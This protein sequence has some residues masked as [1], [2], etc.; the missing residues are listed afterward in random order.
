M[1]L[2]S[3]TRLSLSNGIFFFKLVVE[4]IVT[5][6]NNKFFFL[7]IE[8]KRVLFQIIFNWQVSIIS[9]KI[10]N[11]GKKKKAQFNTIWFKGPIIPNHTQPTFW[12]HN[13]N[14]IEIIACIRFKQNRA[15]TLFPFE[16][17]HNII[18][19]TYAYL[20]NLTIVGL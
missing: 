2:V 7:K 19:I 11:F 18:K 1:T 12:I 10:Y 20:Y 4:T 3:T 8:F 15:N 13:F 16:K 14:W 17:M 5:F 6:L 9:N